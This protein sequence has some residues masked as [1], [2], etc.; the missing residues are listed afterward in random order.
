MLTYKQSNQH[1]NLFK[2]HHLKYPSRLEDLKRSHLSG[3]VYLRGWSEE[4]EV[5]VAR[6]VLKVVKMF[7]VVDEVVDQVIE[8]RQTFLCTEP[9]LFKSR[10]PKSLPPPLLKVTF[11][12]HTVHLKNQRIYIMFTTLQKEIDHNKNLQCNNQPASLKWDFYLN[13]KL[14][15]HL[16]QN[17]NKATTKFP[18]GR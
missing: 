9:P 12:T 18:N 3:I 17:K 13:H 16:Q 7:W 2:Q 8:G 5:V 14:N 4:I 6:E 15:L 10:V 11:R 1:N